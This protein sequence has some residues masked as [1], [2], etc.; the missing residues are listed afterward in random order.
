FAFRVH[1]G[2]T[3]SRKQHITMVDR[4][5]ILDLHALVHYPEYMQMGEASVSP[6]PTADVTGPEQ[7]QVEV[8]VQVEGEVAEGEIQWLEVAWK[9]V[10][11]L[12]REERVWFQGK[13]PDGVVAE[14]N[15]QWD[16]EKHQRPTHHEPPVAGVHS[17]QFH[18][19]PIGFQVLPDDHLFAYVYIVPE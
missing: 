19:A 18:T 1:G 2:E 10:P 17:H 11:V 7:S 12:D 16:V 9:P 4:P 13:L 3:W 6:Q 5:R 14:G 8:Q 15:W